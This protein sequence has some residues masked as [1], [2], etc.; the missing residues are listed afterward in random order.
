MLTPELLALALAL[1][2][3]DTVVLMSQTLLRT[4]LP[5]FR[6][7]THEHNLIL[8]IFMRNELIFVEMTFVD[9]QTDRSG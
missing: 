1:L 7:F 8:F 5:L 9:F 4:S 2:A 6:L 3:L